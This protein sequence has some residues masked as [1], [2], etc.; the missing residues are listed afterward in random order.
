M[1][2][3]ADTR[4]IAPHGLGRFAKE[5]IKR[6]PN[7]E[8]LELKSKLLSPFDPL[9]LSIEVLRRKPNVYFSPGFNPPL[10]SSV[11]T[12]FTI[13]DLIHLKFPEEGSRFKDIYYNSFLKKAVHQSFAVL[14]FSEY[15]KN[16]IVEWSKVDPNKIKIVGCGVGNEYSPIGDVY[17]PGF[18]YLLYIGNNKPHKNVI[19][20]LKAFSAARIPHTIK[21][22]LRVSGAS[23]K[24]YTQ[25]LQQLSILDR[26]VFLDLIPDEILPSYYRGAK[27][28][29]F[30][31]LYEGF[32]L[33]PLEAMACGIPVIT[34]NI[35]SL[36]EVVGDA[37][38]LVDPMSINS[39]QIG[40][41]SIIVNDSL[42]E[43][44]SHLGLLQAKKFNWDNTS[45][46]VYEILISATK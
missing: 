35:T 7:I 25:E 17:Q 30:P 26:V 40:I 6:I 9:L 24:D 38:I 31:S 46:I 11:P 19:R 34:S 16:E 39:I 33:P 18:P 1:K 2:Y 27:A 12:I 42:S 10:F 36:P 4:W 45:K 37:A 44:L 13:G 22:L 15:S 3:L 20:L 8:T 5:V 21:L 29:V 23:S 32:G 28:L 41:E 43:N 14:T